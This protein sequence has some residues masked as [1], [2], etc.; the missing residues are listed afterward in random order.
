MTFRVSL[1]SRAELQLYTN[2]LWWAENRSTEQA[3]RWLDG[4]QRELHSLA[5]DPH[6]WPLAPESEVLPFVARQMPYGVARRKTHRAIFEVR[7][8][9]IIVHAIR[10]LAQETLSAEDFS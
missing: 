6:Q 5:D 4:F 9:E 7:A 3:V 1:S 8:D 10:H 2:A